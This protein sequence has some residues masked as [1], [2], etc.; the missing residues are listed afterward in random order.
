MLRYSSTANPNLPIL[1][2]LSTLIYTNPLWFLPLS[3][4]LSIYLSISISISIYIYIYIYNFIERERELA[5]WIPS[6]F[7]GFL[8]WWY[9]QIIHFN[10][11]FHSVPSVL[12]YPRLWKP[13]LGD[14]LMIAVASQQLGH[15]DS[16]PAT[17]AWISEAT[18]WWTYKK[19]WKMAIYSGFSH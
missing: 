12:G 14:L 5:Y 2:G 11:M 16:R 9:H 6:S 15:R 17:D 8:K 1:H 7:G 10:R 4:Y 3:I 18:L 19:Q 13:H